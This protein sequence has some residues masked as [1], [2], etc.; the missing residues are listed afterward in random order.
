MNPYLVV[1]K[2]WAVLALYLLG[3]FSVF[4]ACALLG[5]GMVWPFR[6]RLIAH[7]WCIRTEKIVAWVLFLAAAF[8]FQVW[9]TR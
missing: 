8:L 2:Q 3:G 6:K 9:W 5:V 7:G 1:A 4:F